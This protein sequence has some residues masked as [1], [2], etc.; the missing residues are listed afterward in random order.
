MI[1]MLGANLLCIK[2][3]LWECQVILGT[4]HF[5]V[6]PSLIFSG[7]KADRQKK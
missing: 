4:D 2:I 3:K 7:K 1:E 6:C 5:P